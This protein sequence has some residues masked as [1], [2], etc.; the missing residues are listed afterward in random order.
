MCKPDANGSIKKKEDT[1]TSSLGLVS[2]RVAALIYKMLD[3]LVKFHDFSMT[4][5]PYFKTPHL[6]HDLGQFWSKFYDFSRNLKN[7]EIP[8]LFHNRGNPDHMQLMYFQKMH[9]NIDRQP[10]FRLTH[11]T[12]IIYMLTMNFFLECNKNRNFFYPM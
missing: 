10:I 2:R 9:F 4:F 6:F 11:N 8:W 5:C 12:Q 1:N 3:L 7:P